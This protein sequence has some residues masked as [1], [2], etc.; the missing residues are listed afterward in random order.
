MDIQRY[1]QAVLAADIDALLTQFSA[2]PTLHVPS[3]RAPFQG[4]RE[5]RDILPVALAQFEDLDF[6]AEFAKEDGH[7]LQ[8]TALIGIERARGVLIMELVDDVIA[9]LTVMV[10]PYDADHALRALMMLALD[11]TA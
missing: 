10:Q 2:E 5:V 1:R 8:F 4:R 7:V 9:E 11:E 3:R 6:T